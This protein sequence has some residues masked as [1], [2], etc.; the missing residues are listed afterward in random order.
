MYAYLL[1]KYQASAYIWKEPKNFTLTDIITS[2]RKTEKNC[3][4]SGN[5]HMVLLHL[6]CDYSFV[7]YQVKS[8][9]N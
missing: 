7:L 5:A 4:D 1:L 8:E 2:F 6:N 3:M 9:E